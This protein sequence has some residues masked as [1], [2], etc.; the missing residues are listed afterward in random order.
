MVRRRC[1]LL[2]GVEP[3]ANSGLRKARKTAPSAG[4]EASSGTH[5][6][7]AGVE[8]SLTVAALVCVRWPQPP[9]AAPAPCSSMVTRDG[10]RI[11]LLQLRQA[12]GGSAPYPPSSLVVHDQAAPQPAVAQAHASPCGRQRLH[13]QP[14]CDRVDRRGAADVTHRSPPHP[15]AP[16]LGSAPQ[17]TL[18]PRKRAGAASDGGRASA[19]SGGSPSSCCPHATDGRRLRP[20]APSTFCSRSRQAR[21]RS[22]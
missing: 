8:L 17:R 7:V 13:P 18:R 19:A 22:F 11:R 9:N 21:K 2:A 5:S 10:V 16:R 15:P 14:F 12:P 4:V 20:Y 3:L 1:S 6:L